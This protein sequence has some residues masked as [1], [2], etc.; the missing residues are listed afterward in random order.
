MHGLTDDGRRLVEDVARRYD[1]SPD[2]VLVLLEA[3]DR[4][5]GVQAQFSHPDLGGMGQ[6]SKGGMI[7]VGD[8]F[9][10]PLKAQVD[11]LATELSEQLERGGLFTPPLSD[12]SR[13][14]SRW[15]A[16][17][18][19]PASAG[20]QNDMHYAVFPAQRRLAIERDGKVTLYDTGDHEITGFSQQ[21]STDQSLTFTSQHGPVDHKELPGVTGVD[22]PE[23][24]ADPTPADEPRTFAKDADPFHN[25]ERLHDLRERNIIPAE[26][27]E[28]KKAELLGRL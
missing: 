6:W 15:P 12:G 9:N 22:A 5:Q 20:S 17:L 26:E 18:G 10:Q 21:Q 14:P 19:H 23:P 7:M 28:A 3:L 27:Y 25:I 8:M 11:A 4:G 16:E 1:I 13:P 2:A 24:A